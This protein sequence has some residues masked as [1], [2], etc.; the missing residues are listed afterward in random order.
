MFCPLYS[1]ARLAGEKRRDFSTELDKSTQN[2]PTSTKS[3]PVQSRLQYFPKV[4]LRSQKFTISGQKSRRFRHKSSLLSFVLSARR[5][6]PTRVRAILTNCSR[7]R[8]CFVNL[9]QRKLLPCG[10]LE[11]LELAPSRTVT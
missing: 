3:E 7:P 6:L 10:R 11:S 8:I 2:T 9:T 1:E 4:S 5:S